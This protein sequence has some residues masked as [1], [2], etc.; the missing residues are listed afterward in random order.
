MIISIWATSVKNT[1]EEEGEG[2]FYEMKKFRGRGDAAGK[3]VA[4]LH[5]YMDTE[6]V[7]LAVPRG[8]VPIGAFIA[9]QLHLPLEVVLSKK[10][11]HP[12]SKEY[13]IGAVSLHS[14]ILNEDVGVSEDYID[15]EV[16]AI[17]DSLRERSKLYIGNREPVSIRHKNVIIVDDG[18]ATGSTVLAIVELVKMENPAKIIIAVPVAAPDTIDTLKQRV[19]EVVCVMAPPDFTHV[20]QFYDSFEQVTDEEVVKLLREAYSGGVSS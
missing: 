16:E 3:L 7:V 17:R 12:M 10:I 1:G 2:N 15:S 13:A 6:T 18:I 14:V 4:L 5:K 11:G 20:G 8:G 9:K 19:N